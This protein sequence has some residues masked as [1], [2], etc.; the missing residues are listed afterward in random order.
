MINN[1]SNDNKNSSGRERKLMIANCRGI[2]VVSC[3]L[4]CRPLFSPTTNTP[5]C[6]EKKF[7]HHSVRQW[8]VHAVLLFVK[9]I[10]YLFMLSF[11][12][13][14]LFFFFLC[15]QEEE[16]VHQSSSQGEFYSYG[17]FLYIQQCSLYFS[18]TTVYVVVIGH[19][20]T[21]WHI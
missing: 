16:L 15:C 1:N 8:S 2:R 6:Q 3:Q 9:V 10:S 4:Y 14:P 18:S 13:S 12:G 19:F 7:L 11:T 5:S 17:L 20:K 21:V